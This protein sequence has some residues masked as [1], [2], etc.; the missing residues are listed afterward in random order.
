MGEKTTFI[1]ILEDQEGRKLIEQIE[2]L[3][4]DEEATLARI[5]TALIKKLKTK[6]G[7]TYIV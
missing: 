3:L 4:Y 2:E 1:Q 6:F 7:Y 5:R